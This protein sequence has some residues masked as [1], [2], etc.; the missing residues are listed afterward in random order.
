MNDSQMVEPESNSRV[1]FKKFEDLL[2]K[3]TPRDLF[4]VPNV[5]RRIETELKEGNLSICKSERDISDSIS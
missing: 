5:T 4:A 2:S 3:T 1:Y